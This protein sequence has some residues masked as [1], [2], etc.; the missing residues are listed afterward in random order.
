MEG[1][2]LAGF[3]KSDEN[4]FREIAVKK[5]YEELMALCKNLKRVLSTVSEQLF[6]GTKNRI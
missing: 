4:L 2:D 1:G 5:D 6:L 3:L